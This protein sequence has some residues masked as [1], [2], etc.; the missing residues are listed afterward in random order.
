MFLFYWDPYYYS[1]PTDRLDRVRRRISGN[2]CRRRFPDE[3]P[4]PFRCILLFAETGR[5]QR[6][7][8]ARAIYG[9]TRR[10]NWERT[11]EAGLK[12]RLPQLRFQ[13]SIFEQASSVG[14]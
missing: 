1:I 8:C 4:S 7:I 3:G 10:R 5:T 6:G 9:P 11:F 2:E 12:V 14:H 13:L